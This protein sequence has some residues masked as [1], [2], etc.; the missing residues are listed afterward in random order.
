MATARSQ[1]CTST[2]FTPTRPASPAGICIPAISVVP[3]HA[4]GSCHAAT[5]ASSCAGSFVRQSAGQV[6]RVGR[7]PAGLAAFSPALRKATV[8]PS[9]WSRIAA[10]GHVGARRRVGQ[11]VVAHPGDHARHLGGLRGEV[12]IRHVR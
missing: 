12:E 7:R 11:L 6:R 3:S 9:K 1:P 4:A 5:S 10:T 2:S 8:S